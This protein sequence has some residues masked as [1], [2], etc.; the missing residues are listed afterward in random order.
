MTISVTITAGAGGAQVRTA[1]ID[2]GDFTAQQTL[3]TAGTTNA[4]HTYRTAGTFTATVT[5]VDAA[6]ETVQATAPIV[7]KPLAPITVT[8]S[9]SANPSVGQVTTFNANVTLPPGDAIASFDWDFGDGSGR[10]TTSPV[11]TRVYQSA[12]I[13]A[14]SVRVTTTD[15]ATGNAVIDVRVLASPFNVQLT[16]SN[17]TPAVGEIVTFT[18]TVTFGFVPTRFEWDF[19]DGSGISTTGTGTTVH[20]YT[21]AGQKSVSVRAVLADQTFATASLNVIVQ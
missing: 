16:A 5:A 2:F 4:V 10:T 14:A 19:G 17:L 11:T 21:T 18:A 12:G 7:I 9:V 8:L 13:F 6:G 20:Q 3:S 1:T 15:G